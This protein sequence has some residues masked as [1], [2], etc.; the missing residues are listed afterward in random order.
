MST[1]DTG[2]WYIKRKRDGLWF[3]GFAADN[4]PR[5]ADRNSAKPYA[6]E[7]EA[8][9]QADFLPGESHVTEPAAD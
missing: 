5:F 6:T 4:T 8:K 7:L 9:L 2:N 3:A 1:I